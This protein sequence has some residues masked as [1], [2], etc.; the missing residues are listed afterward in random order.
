MPENLEAAA[1]GQSDQQSRELPKRIVVPPIKGEMV[2][3]RPAAVEDLDRMDA[4]EAYVGASGI[5]GKDRVAE[6]GAVRA[7]VWDVYRS[8]R[9]V[10][11]VRIVTFKDV[12]VEEVQKTDIDIPDSI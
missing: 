11:N 4:I 3:L 2:H 5:T 9:F 8:S 7:W 1:Q 6:R 10:K 12:N